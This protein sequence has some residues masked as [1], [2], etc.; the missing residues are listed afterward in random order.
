MANMHSK[1]PFSRGYRFPVLNNSSAFRNSWICCIAYYFI[2]RVYIDVCLHSRRRF[3]WTQTLWSSAIWAG[4]LANHMRL[5]DV[6]RVSDLTP[7]CLGEHSHEYAPV[8]CSRA[9]KLSV[10]GHHKTRSRIQSWRSSNAMDHIELF[11]LIRRSPN[12]EGVYMHFI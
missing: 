6:F 9:I 10:S 7:P 2:M 8:D 4:S 11:L 5:R 1:W 3:L 12:R